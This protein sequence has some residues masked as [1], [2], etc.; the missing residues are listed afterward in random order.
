[1]LEQQQGSNV[2]AI[3]AFEASLVVW[4]ELSDD[5][6]IA[7]EL[8]SLGVA[9]WAVGEG[10]VARV[11]LRESVAVA[12]AANNEPRLAAALSNL[13]IVGLTDGMVTSAI[14]DLEQALVIDVRLADRWAV[15]VDRCN[16]GAAFACAGR[17]EDARASLLEVVPTAV[18]LRDNDLIASMLETCA[19]LAAR[20]ERH[21]HAAM[22]IGGAETLRREAEIPRTQPEDELLDRELQSTH[23]A[24]G[25]DAYGQE[26]RR[27]AETPVED[28]IANAVPGGDQSDLDD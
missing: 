14:A 12:R 6:G 25:A 3:V 10:D 21:E 5:A 9:R 4:R 20:S 22:L 2:E 19:I 1:V 8:N 27:G 11:L 17:L 7:K 16:L 13:G 15:A 18:D 23:A 24:L 26:W 28:L